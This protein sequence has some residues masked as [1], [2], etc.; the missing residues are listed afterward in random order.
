MKIIGNV[1]L[2]SLSSVHNDTTSLSFTTG[3]LT[4]TI[5]SAQQI[6]SDDGNTVLGTKVFDALYVETARAS[7]IST[8]N[9][10]WTSNNSWAWSGALDADNN[11]FI[12]SRVGDAEI[13]I[14]QTLPV[15]SLKDP[16]P[17]L[18]KFN[19]S[20]QLEWTIKISP[21]N[22]NF[23][24][25]GQIFVDSS[26]VL[27]P[28]Y[29]SY[30]GSDTIFVMKISQLGEVIWQKE[31]THGNF[32]GCTFSSYNSGP[33]ISPFGLVITMNECG[34]DHIFILNSTT[35]ELLNT[36]SSTVDFVET[37]DTHVFNTLSAVNPVSDELFI[38]SSNQWT[39]AVLTKY[40]NS[41]V[42]E[43]SVPLQSPTWTLPESPWRFDSSKIV[44]SNTGEL[45]VVIG[46]ETYSSG[47]I[48][49][50]IDQTNGSVVEAFTFTSDVPLT[51]IAEFTCDSVSITNNVM[52]ITGSTHNN[53]WTIE[54][55]FA[56]SIDL[57]TNTVIAAKAISANDGTYETTFGDY[58]NHSATHLCIIGGAYNFTPKGDNDERKARSI[59][60]KIPKSTFN[61]SSDVFT[62]A[63][64][65]LVKTVGGLVNGPNPVTYTP[66]FT[67][68]FSSL[69]LSPLWSVEFENSILIAPVFDNTSDHNVKIAGSLDV[70]QCI[71]FNGDSGPN[72]SVIMQV[73]QGIARWTVLDT[74]QNSSSKLVAYDNGANG[75][76][77]ARLNQ[78]PLLHISNTTLN[79]GL[80]AGQVSSPYASNNVLIGNDS[81]MDL[82]NASN[83]T[84]IGSGS[85]TK[86]KSGSDN[87][88]LG[89]G[90]LHAN[91]TGNKNIAIGK[92]SL[93]NNVTG[94]DNI[95][96]GFENLT[97]IAIDGMIAIGGRSSQTVSNILKMSWIS[98][99]ETYKIFTVGDSDFTLV[100]APNN[101]VGTVFVATNWGVYPPTPNEGSVAFI[102]V[103]L[104]TIV[105]ATSMIAD[106][107]Y[108]IN[109]VG[110]TDFT[111][112]GAASNNIGQGFYATGPGTGD[113]T[114]E[115]ESSMGYSVAL[116]HKTLQ[117]LV[118]PGGAV[119]IGHG[120]LQN[121]TNSFNTAVGFE[122]MR[123]NI[124]GWG[125]TALGFG[126]LRNNVSGIRL[127][128]VGSSALWANTTG[129]NNTALGYRALEENT[130]GG[131]NTAVGQ[132]LLYN[133]TG[134]WNTAIGESALRNNTTGSGNIAV[135][136]AL[137]GN[138]IGNNN[139][140]IGW[141]AL[142]VSTEND[143]MAIGVNSLAGI[144]SGTRNL[145]IGYYAGYN[146]TSG[147]NNLIIGQWS[148]PAA[149]MSNNIIIAIGDGTVRLQH[150]NTKWISTTPFE[151][152]DLILPGT[153]AS[154]SLNSNEGTAGQ[155]LTSAGPN[156]TPT[157]T[158]PRQK[159][160]TI[161]P[162]T[163][164]YTLQLTDAFDTLIRF[165]SATTSTLTVPNDSTANLPIGSAVLVGW[166][167][168]GSVT[169]AAA[170]GVTINT[171]STL[172]INKR[173]GKVT[174]IKV[175]ANEWDLEGNLTP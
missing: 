60:I 16:A 140:A 98:I 1:E 10:V 57:D 9:N 20:N 77:F 141:Q 11:L 23:L 108:Y 45:Y 68:V 63:D 49:A 120:A 33:Y 157:W 97:D 8:S 18:S 80:N 129:I 136:T 79:I 167:G 106:V 91:E 71:T 151:V 65:T 170:G 94:S 7:Y 54:K 96:I 85:G 132:A 168:V 12:F 160:I 172:T 78:T 93:Y 37:A 110:S 126:T 130:V 147:S 135:G 152:S 2:N 162:Q 70:A 113:G 145:A 51:E 175:A 40:S 5:N 64:I 101:N 103:T 86:T 125:D 4:T 146:L 171:P 15:S 156:A 84:Y 3:N 56:V 100:G 123:S 122:S 150:D 42:Y 158:T 31:I 46:D 90:A 159:T 166:H 25:P 89:Y 139:I 131:F 144:T 81:G 82:V 163:G 102:P 115:R 161:S 35:G 155:V 58:G 83:N 69:T 50:K 43:W 53:D 95:S 112:V 67:P 148:G 87:I 6:N 153:T 142:N 118:S 165:N 32:T 28:I 127:T 27:K 62:T 149:A 44:F 124:S 26:D 48:V 143:N 164:N 174:L 137:G 29:I 19:S 30:P 41:L 76:I 169:I 21:P 73:G 119:A 105:P 138:L 99:G 39:Q 38:M 133:T 34:T 121:S 173:Y 117:K 154:I 107:W 66:K 55:F 52:Y 134:N 14:D 24:N 88:A 72:G 74:L 111:L 116:G 17:I 59:V 61:F 92:S 114:V 22:L 13:N 109:T 128:A 104:D 47:I 36:I 75:G